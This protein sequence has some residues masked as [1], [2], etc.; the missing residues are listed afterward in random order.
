[1]AHF[2]DPHGARFA[3]WQPGD[4]GGLDVVTDPG[5]LAW[6]ELVTSDAAAAQAFYAAVFAWKFYK[7]PMAGM[8]YV[9]VTPAGKDEGGETGGVYELSDTARDAAAPQAR[10]YP[11]FEV[12][13]CDATVRAALDSGGRVPVEPLDLDGVGRMALIADPRGALFHVITSVPAGTP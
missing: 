1:M 13:D 6:T 9:V 8:E 4:R 11:Y 2:A 7:T 5:S 10:W 3:V 12:T